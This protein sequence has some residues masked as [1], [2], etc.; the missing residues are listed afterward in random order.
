[1]ATGTARLEEEVRGAG[2]EDVVKCAGDE[3]EG[4]GLVFG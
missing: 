3:A 2:A 1:M 4:E